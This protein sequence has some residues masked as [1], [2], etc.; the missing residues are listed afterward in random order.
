MVLLFFFGRL[1]KALYLHTQISQKRRVGRVV[2]C[3]G[4]ENRCPGDRTGGSNP[5][6][7]AFYFVNGV[8]HLHI[9]KSL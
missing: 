5:S 9:E 7:S 2:E 1:K 6:L 8:L 4:L 3:G